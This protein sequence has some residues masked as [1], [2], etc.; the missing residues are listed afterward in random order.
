M[1]R[2]YTGSTQN[3][4]DRRD[5]TRKRKGRARKS[6]LKNGDVVSSGECFRKALEDAGN[7]AGSPLADPQCL[8]ERD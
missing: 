6:K 2:P 3:E 8:A 7:K 5:Q 1:D 4:A